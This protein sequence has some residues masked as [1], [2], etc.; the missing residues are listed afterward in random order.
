MDTEVAIPCH[1]LFASFCSFIMCLLPY[2]SRY[3][4]ILSENR[5]IPIIHPTESWK[6]TERMVN[7][8]H[9]SIT[10]TAKASAVGPSYSRSNTIAKSIN[11]CMMQALVMDG[12]KPAMAANRNSAGM[13]TRQDSTRLFAKSV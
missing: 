3:W 9:T 13:P 10:K 11:D 12:V 8:L 4:R 5:K 7:G 2:L 1:S 6:L